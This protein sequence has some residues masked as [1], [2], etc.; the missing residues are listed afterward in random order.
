MAAMIDL[1]ARIRNLAER[2]SR[3]KFAEELGEVQRLMEGLQADQ[4]ALNEQ[5]AKL[6][7]ENVQLKATLAALEQQ[8]PKSAEE[9]TA[10]QIEELE[11][12][13]EKILI[14]IANNETPKESVISFFQLTKVKGDEYFDILMTRNL[15]RV[16]YMLDDDVYYVATPEGREYLENK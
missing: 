10:Q 3:K 15:I 8:K 9:Q 4:A 2:F 13:A 16:K 14:D 6:M 11:E 12:I 1:A 7:A 5:N